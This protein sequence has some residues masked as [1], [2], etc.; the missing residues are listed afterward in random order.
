MKT[1]LLALA[2]IAIA[3]SLASAGFFMMRTGDTSEGMT[4]KE[5]AW[6]MFLSL[7]TRVALSVALFASI[8]LAWKMGWIRPSGL[9]G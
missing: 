7:A 2:F 9:T 5:R 3:A 4:D 6:R 1:V 8:L